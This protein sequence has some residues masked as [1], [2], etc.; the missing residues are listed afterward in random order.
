MREKADDQIWSSGGVTRATIHWLV[1]VEH[2]TT[3][4]RLKNQKQ[5]VKILKHPYGPLNYIKYS[6]EN[7]KITPKAKLLFCL[8]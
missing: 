3:S 5:N 1:R 4:F 2:V 8:F 6:W 7:T